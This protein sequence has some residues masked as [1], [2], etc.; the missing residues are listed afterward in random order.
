[1]NAGKIRDT[2]KIRDIRRAPSVMTMSDLKES[3]STPTV[4]KGP[5]PFSPLTFTPKIT[6]TVMN[7]SPIA[8]YPTFPI[9]QTN[10][11]IQST[12]QK[13]PFLINNDR[14]GFS[15]SKFDV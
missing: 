2:T 8:S 4:V 15:V 9:V 11:P 7:S 10:L 14:T 6:P 1:V 12:V 5:Q 13:N 3:P